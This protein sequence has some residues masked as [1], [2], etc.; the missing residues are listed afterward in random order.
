MKLRIKL[1]SSASGIKSG[2][3]FLYDDIYEFKIIA[4]GK[5]KNG[6]IMEASAGSSY[7]IEKDKESSLVRRITR[8]EYLGAVDP[9]EFPWQETHVYYEF[10]FDHPI[11]D[12]IKKDEELRRSNPNLYFNLRLPGFDEKNSPTLPSRKIFIFKNFNGA[13]IEDQS[14]PTLPRNPVELIERFQKWVDKHH[15]FLSEKSV[16]TKYRFPVNEKAYLEIKE[17]D[18]KRRLPVNPFYWSNQIKA[19]HTVMRYWY[20]ALEFLEGMRW[21]KLIEKNDYNR[22]KSL[23]FSKLSLI[24]KMRA[25]FE[26][27]PVEED[28]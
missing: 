12:D 26:K 18:R 23:I 27:T 14:L 25:V 8:S 20:W 3:I 28:Y 11:Y 7:K 24:K 10:E 6:W 22:A 16:S 4:L 9:R 15:A 2:K 21:N 5:D 19:L 13:L 1:A 17:L